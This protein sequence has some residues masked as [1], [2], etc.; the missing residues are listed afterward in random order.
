MGLNFFRS[1]TTADKHIYIIRRSVPRDAN[2]WLFDN[3][4]C[5][6][7]IIA[8]CKLH[9]LLDIAYWNYRKFCSLAFWWIKYVPDLASLVGWLVGCCCCCCCLMYGQNET[10]LSSWGH[11]R[12]RSAWSSETNVVVAYVLW[13]THLNDG[14][15]AAHLN[16][17]LNDGHHA[18]HLNDGQ[19][20]IR[21][22]LLSWN[23][24]SDARVTCG[25][26]KGNGQFVHR[27]W[28]YSR[29][30]LST[31][32]NGWCNFNIIEPMIRRSFVLAMQE[33]RGAVPARLVRTPTKLVTWTPHWWSGS[34]HIRE[35]SVVNKSRTITCQIAFGSDRYKSTFRVNTVPIYFIANID[36]HAYHSWRNL[37]IYCF[38]LFFIRFTVTSA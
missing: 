25:F 29:R 7:D 35:D 30:S 6:N 13:T 31:S 16:D 15:H 8:R 10:E 11:L 36:M 26:W 23:M 33:N 5:A 9:F 37:C 4:C 19:W 22:P 12:H 20:S 27:L 21:T 24:M 3:T 1:Y 32:L 28:L 2:T 34:A 14:Q 38:S 18:A 17:G